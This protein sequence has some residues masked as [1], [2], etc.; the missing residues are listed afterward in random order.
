M[1]VCVYLAAYVVLCIGSGLASGSSN[2]PYRLR[3]EYYETEEEAIA[4]QRAAEQLMDKLLLI[5]SCWKAQ[6]FIL[7]S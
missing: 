2:E 4:H 7:T 3:K 1:F 5:H 6:S